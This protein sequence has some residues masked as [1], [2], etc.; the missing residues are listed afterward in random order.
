MP[1]QEAL[2]MIILIRVAR[3]KRHVGRPG[4]II[5]VEFGFQSPYVAPNAYRVHQSVATFDPIPL[6]KPE[7]GPSLMIGW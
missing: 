4:V 3:I 7:G 2:W 6:L 5:R 1:R